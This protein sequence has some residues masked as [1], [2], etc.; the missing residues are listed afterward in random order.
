MPPGITLHTTCTCSHFSWHSKKRHHSHWIKNMSEIIEHLHNDCL[1]E[2]VCIGSLQ[3]LGAHWRQNVYLWVATRKHR[4]IGSDLLCENCGAVISL[5]SYDKQ[6]CL[7][8]CN[9]TR[10]PLQQKTLFVRVQGTG[11]LHQHKSF[12]CNLRHTTGWSNLRTGF[13]RDVQ[14]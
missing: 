10:A 1:E 8:N 4:Y 3:K 2:N 7:H 14:R 11:E 5:E 6:L 9:A 12:L 13:V